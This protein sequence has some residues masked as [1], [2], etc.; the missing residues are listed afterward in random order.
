VLAVDFYWRSLD[1]SP[2]KRVEKAAETVFAFG[3]YKTIIFQP[4]MRQAGTGDRA[5]LVCR[6]SSGAQG[7]ASQQPLRLWAI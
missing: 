3:D 1:D 4:L 5:L 2:K 7:R 6:K